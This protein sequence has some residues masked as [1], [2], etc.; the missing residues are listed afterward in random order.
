M[1]KALS[2][3]RKTRQKQGL[4]IF[5]VGIGSADG[6]LVTVTDA[7]G[8]S[9][10]IRD[11]KGQVVKA[12]LNKELLQQIATPPRGGFYQ[13]LQG[14]NT[15]NVLY[16]NGLSLLPKAEGKSKM[17]RQ[18]YREQY[19]WPLTLAILLLIAEMFFPER[20]STGRRSGLKKR[21]QHPTPNIQ[22][23]NPRRRC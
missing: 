21:N 11:E 8:N 23:H 18:Q 9:D 10:Y 5:T 3:R 7:S 17:I 14:A 1:M 20:K 2:K 6:T 4:K 13:P 19:Y 22:H 15:I 12:K 16:D